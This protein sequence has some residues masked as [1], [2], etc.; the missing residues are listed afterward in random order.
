MSF[1][2]IPATPTSDG[3]LVALVHLFP[4]SVLIYNVARMSPTATTAA[5][6][7]VKDITEVI[8]VMFSEDRERVWWLRH[9]D[10]FPFLVPGEEGD[11]QDNNEED[12]ED[13]GELWE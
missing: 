9:R 2:R 6:V 4:P 10:Q 7:E 13:D 5:I 12:D 8:G 1:T 3:T 11:D